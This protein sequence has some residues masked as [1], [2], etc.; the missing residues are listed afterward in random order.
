MFKKIKETISLLKKTCNYVSL[1]SQTLFACKG[2][3]VFLNY[4]FSSA[5]IPKNLSFPFSEFSKLGKIDNIESLTVSGI[6]LT[7]KSSAGLEITLK[8]FI[9]TTEEKSLDDFHVNWHVTLGK[10]EIE[11]LKPAMSSDITRK[12][13]YQLY[14]DCNNSVTTDDY[15]LHMV[16][17]PS[18]SLPYPV[19]VPGDIVKALKPKKGNH[20]CV[21]TLEDK[22]VVKCNGLSFVFINNLDEYKFPPYEKLLERQNNPE[23][24]EIDNPSSRLAS[25]PKNGKLRVVIMESNGVL[26]LKLDHDEDIKFEYVASLETKGEFVK[27]FNVDLLVDAIPK[28]YSRVLLKYDSLDAFSPLEIETPMGLALVMPVRL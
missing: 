24:L 14:I 16:S 21:G 4:T 9:P 18:S 22:I 8:G 11:Y 6:D 1:G 3:D 15:R 5:T 27:G 12:H 17:T 7:V 19:G 26:K 13:L 10:D 28:Q 2:F 20:V 25:I 23:I